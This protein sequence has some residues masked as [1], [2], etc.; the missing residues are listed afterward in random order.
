MH[1]KNF[2][3][4][5]AAIAVA[6][7][8]GSAPALYAADDQI[9]LEDDT[10]RTCSSGTDNTCRTESSSTSTCLEW[11]PVSANGTVSPGG[12]G[13]GVTFQCKTTKVTTSTSTWYWSK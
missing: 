10:A 2:R 11:V 12:G 3:S 8:L 5:L 6:A 13:L 1:T 7:A 9:A 4:I